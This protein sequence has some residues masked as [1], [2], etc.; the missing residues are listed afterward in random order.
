M[1]EHE[2]REGFAKGRRLCQ[3]EWSAPNEIT[4]VDKLAKEGVC[5]VTAWKYDDN[6]QC[7]RRYAT[8][9]R[10]ASRSDRGGA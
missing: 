4:L 9:F 3:E 7:E 8:G 6:F 2:M 1:T 5:S 10:S